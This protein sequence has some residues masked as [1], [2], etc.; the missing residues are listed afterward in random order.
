[1]RTYKTG[2]KNSGTE[3]EDSKLEILLPLGPI[4]RIIG[5]F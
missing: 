4:E 5:V 2:R 3:T 1:M